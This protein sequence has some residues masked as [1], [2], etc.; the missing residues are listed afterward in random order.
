MVVRKITIFL[1]LVFWV[2]GCA[3]QR[4]PCHS[5]V[6]CPE[7]KY[8]WNATLPNLEEM[9]VLEQ[10]GMPYLL[11]ATPPY[12]PREAWGN[13]V[14]GMVVIKFD[15]TPEGSPENITVLTSIP[16]GVFD[17]AGVEAMKNSIYSETEKGAPGFQRRF[18]WSVSM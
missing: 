17:K 16:E 15:V 1:Y 5:F 10:K 3:A 9:K 2:V 12:Y 13:R 11:K 7:S 18:T 8:S 14:E 4:S 6:E